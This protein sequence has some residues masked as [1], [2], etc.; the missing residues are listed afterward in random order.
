M[1]RMAKERIPVL[2][3]WIAI[4]MILVILGHFSFPFAPPWYEKWHAWL[5][6]FHMGA[7]FF[8]SGYLVKYTY[9]ELTSWSDYFWYIGK[10]LIK[11]GIPFL[12][13]GISLTIFAI[14]RKG[15]SGADYGAALQKLFMDPMSSQVLYLWFIYVL[16]FY[17]VLAPVF[18]QFVPVGLVFGGIAGLALSYFSLPR[19]FAIHCFSRYLIFFVSGILICTFQK[20]VSRLPS[21]LAWGAVPCFILCSMPPGEVLYLYSCMLSLPC[22]YLLCLFLARGEWLRNIA[23]LISK[24]CFSIYLLQMI[25]IHV[26]ALLFI[27]LPKNDWTYLSFMVSG[28]F[29][30]ISG[31]VLVQRLFAK[32]TNCL[33]RKNETCESRG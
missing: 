15:G 8:A 22:L 19:L 14:W 3:Y 2:D 11:F 9:K 10:K 31:S 4:L 1:R 7:F 18:C 32:I 28:L 17:Y 5:Y 25:F 29:V 6:S 13:F 20:H 12:F 33:S 23:E 21:W 26:L 24:N 27:K 30:S 16:F